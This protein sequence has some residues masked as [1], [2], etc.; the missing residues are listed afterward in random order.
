MKL[1]T[2]PTS[3]YGR[4][5]RVILLEKG[6]PFEEENP[7][8]SGA[9]LAD[10]NPLGKVPTLLLS[11][12]TCLFDSVVIA[13]HLELAHPEPRLLPADAAAKIRCK[14]WEALCDGVCDVVMPAVMERARPAT[15]QRAAVIEKAVGKVTAALT[16]LDAAVAGRRY[17][18]GDSFSLAD[19]CAVCAVGYLRLRFPELLV[20]HAALAAYDA[21]LADHPSVVSTVPP[22]LP[23]RV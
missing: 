18:E 8:T 3:P 2:S 9:N 13:E 17:L 11:D 14:R 6:L 7:F 10:K 23:L 12:G 16:H 22:N 15:D 1:F 21:A 19:I 4:K 5:I 20:G